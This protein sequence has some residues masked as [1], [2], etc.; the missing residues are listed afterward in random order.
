M[1]R[2]DAF[3][4]IRY[5]TDDLAAVTAPPYDVID[6]AERAALEARHPHN[7]VHVDLPRDYD[8][9]GALIRRWLADGVLAVDDPSLYL[10]RMTDDEDQSTLGVIGALGLEPPG[11]G[12]V[13]P[14]ERTTP[15]AKSDR[16][17]LL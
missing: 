13:L 10:Y 2:F 7:V 1:P 17:D 9:A 6:A 4:G 15:K 5:A 16:L 11:E 3:A 8:A 12:D 14:H